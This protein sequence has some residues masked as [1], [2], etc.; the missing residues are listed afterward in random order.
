MMASSQRSVLQPGRRDTCT[1]TAGASV[2]H[3]CRVQVVVGRTTRS[4]R[5]ASDTSA[6][7][8]TLSG[9]RRWRLLRRV[10]SEA[11]LGRRA[12]RCFTVVSSQCWSSVGP[13]QH[14][15]DQRRV[16]QSWS[17]ARPGWRC[18]HIFRGDR[19]SGAGSALSGAGSVVACPHARCRCHRVQGV[20]V[21]E[22]R[23]PRG[24]RSWGRTHPKPEVDAPAVR[25]VPEAGGAADEVLIVAERPAAQHTAM[26][27]SGFQ[28]FP[29]P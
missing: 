22:F 17:G 4:R 10:A 9:S 7:A 28:V 6:R 14:D 27:I 13:V 11:S 16:T 25:V 8:V 19:P 26:R 24:Q 18:Q 2:L 23:G 1:C 20:R 12:E 21:S 3:W 29:L 15:R 5:S